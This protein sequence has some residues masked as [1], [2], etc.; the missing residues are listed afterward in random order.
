M[1]VRL[2][3][4]ADAGLGAS[5]AA[6]VVAVLCLGGAAPGLADRYG[7]KAQDLLLRDRPV[8]VELL[9]VLHLVFAAMFAIAGLRLL[10]RLGGSDRGVSCRH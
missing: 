1:R 3:R 5:V 4:A 8:E 9:W 7:S 10:M 2:K 6:P